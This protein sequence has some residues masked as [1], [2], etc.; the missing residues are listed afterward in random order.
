M[1]SEK[2]LQDSCSEHSLRRRERDSTSSSNFSSNKTNNSTRSN[3]C[4]R[5]S[6]CSDYSEDFE[7]HSSIPE[8]LKGESVKSKHQA[9]KKESIKKN[10]YQGNQKRA[11]TK[12]AFKMLQHWN[13]SA[14]KNKSQ[15]LSKMNTGGQDLDPVTRHILSARLHKTKEL[16]NEVCDLQR[17]L[18]NARLENRLL[19]QLQ[20]R[21]MKALVK[22]ENEQNN[23]PQL[24]VRHEGEVR[25]LKEMLRK[26]K[27][28]DRNV[29]K[30]L[31]E[32]EAELW[33]TKNSM[34]KLKVLCDKKNLAERDDLTW[35]LTNLTKKLEVDQQ[36]IQNTSRQRGDGRRWRRKISWKTWK[37][38]K[39]KDRRKKELL[40]F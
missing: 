31:K 38:K 37:G 14:F 9:I 21:H 29:S 11:Q 32:A 10:I 13:Q 36:K 7:D 4:D 16:K 23:L 15:N 19:R 34:Q 12:P 22:F 18:E 2:S 39:E 3:K 28:Q 40:G 17:E 30:Q 1:A 6:A 20:Y 8:S 24:L 5:N 33:K 27:Q 25:M 26:S 35:E